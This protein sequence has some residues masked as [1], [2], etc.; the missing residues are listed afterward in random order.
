MKTLYNIIITICSRGIAMAAIFNS[1]IKTLHKG[2]KNI[3]QIIENDM[4][5]DKVRKVWFHSA[6][7][8]EFE[9]GRPIIEAFREANPQI[10]IIITFFS[11]SGYEV[12]KHYKHADYVYYLPFD[13]K[14]NAQKFIRLVNP[15]FA[16]FVK[17][18]FWANYLYCLKNSNIPA[19]SV[20]SIFRQNQIYFKFY[21]KF[22]RNTLK[23]IT[24]FFVQDENSRELLKSININN[25]TIAGD[26]RFDRVL[27]IV[28]KSKMVAV[29]EKF[30]AGHKCL[31]A[32]STWQPDEEI[33]AA[34][35]NSNPA[36]KLIIAP[37]EIKPENI[38]RIGKMFTEQ[39]VVF[40]EVDDDTDLSHCRVLIIDNMGML[41]SLYRYGQVAYVGGGFGIG[42]H[43]TLEAAAYGMPIIFGHNYNRFAEALDLIEL[44]AAFSVNSADELSKI[45][46]RLL[47]DAVLLESTAAAAKKYVVEKTGATEIVLKS[48]MLNVIS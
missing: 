20:S 6:S 37:H 40:S 15:L 13:T 35:I 33:I 23:Y 34:C 17:Y 25:I 16:V 45:I 2:Q 1:K 14:K 8:G 44:G 24:H 46:N 43:N 31:V 28:G 32:G 7:L 3:F 10:K 41:S 38:C 29:A 18:E 19:Y 26:T 5:N 9:Q 21:G 48:L 12:Q 47:T 22:F 30:V 39:S 11:P 4:N 27:Q 42:I 36:V